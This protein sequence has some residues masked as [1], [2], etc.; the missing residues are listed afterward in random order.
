MSTPDD[1]IAAKVAEAVDEVNREAPPDSGAQPEAWPDLELGEAAPA[2]RGEVMEV[3]PERS[4]R[5]M[6]KA[7]L[8]VAVVVLAVGAFLT[9]TQTGRAL[10]PVSTQKEADR[11]VREVERRAQL[12]DDVFYTFTD[13]QGVVHIVDHLDKVP[14]A[15]RSRVKKTR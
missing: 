7:L 2:S 8:G 5:G 14:K 10:L 13:D 4:Y 1:P 11:V 6:V 12:G 15:Y 3:R 9:F